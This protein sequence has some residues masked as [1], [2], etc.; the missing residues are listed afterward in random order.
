MKRTWQILNFLSVGFALAM[1]FIVGAQMIDVASIKEVSDTYA[2]LL[3]PATYAFSIWG[4]IYT[5]LVVFAVYQARD[6]LTPDKD[7]DLPEKMGPYFILANIGNGLWTYIFVSN[8]IG[9]SVVVLLGMVAALFLLL[10]QLNI[11]MFTASIKTTLFV[12]WPL[13]LYTGW[14]LAAS[15]V[16]VASW[17]ISRGITLSESTSAAIIVSFGVAL[18][19]LLYVRNLRELVLASLWGV[20]AVGVMQLQ[21]AESHTVMITAFTASGV[22][23]IASVI[24]AYQNRRENLIGHILKRNT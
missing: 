14:V 2:T 17:L 7:N 23:L 12:W 21:T 13:M 11:A 3:T 19:A 16:N 18:L 20:V 24:H 15:V 22:V 10:R 8:L 9:L 1:N 4:L 5:L 6:L